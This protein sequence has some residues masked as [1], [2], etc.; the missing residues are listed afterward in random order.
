MKELQSN[1]RQLLKGAGAL[2]AFAALLNPGSAFAQTA[3]THG[4]KGPAGSWLAHLTVVVKER[5]TLLQA[6]YTYTADGGLIETDQLTANR[7][8]SD[9]PGH[10]TWARK[11][12][13]EFSS[14]FISFQFDSRGIPAGTLKFRETARLD[15]SGDTYSGSGKLDFFDLNG[16]LFASG[17]FKSR[18]T[19]ILVEPL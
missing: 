5:R 7:Q 17:I 12:E 16:N 2:G 13:H 18:A 9:G 10:G 19:R 14:T 4:E 11:G 8:L 15:E 1:R 3:R 6:L